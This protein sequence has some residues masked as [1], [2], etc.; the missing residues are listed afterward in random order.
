MAYRFI[1]L[2]SG[3]TVPWAALHGPRRDV[4][5]QSPTLKAFAL[6]TLR[7]AGMTKSNEEAIMNSFLE[8]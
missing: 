4:S 5:L 3:E 6:T 1:E 7:Q 2:T 8:Q